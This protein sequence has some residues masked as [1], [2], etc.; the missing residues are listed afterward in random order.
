MN[1]KSGKYTNF[2]SFGELE[3]DFSDQGLT[4]ISGA[5]G[6]GKSTLMDAAAWCL[7][8]E[9][10][11]GGAVD[12]IRTW[13]ESDVTAGS[14]RVT[15]LAGDITVTRIR[16]GGTKNDLFWT[17]AAGQ[18]K[19]G[20][21]IKETQ[22][23]LNS[24]LGISSEL[25]FMAAYFHQFSKADSFFVA[26][27]KERREVLEKIADLS[28]ADKIA[29]KTSA[30][31]KADRAEMEKLRQERTLVFGRQSA[32]KEVEKTTKVNLDNWAGTNERR[33]REISGRM[34]NFEFDKQAA[35]QK[36]EKDL[37]T[38]LIHAQTLEEDFDT[39]LKEAKEEECQFLLEI[40]I[41][42]RAILALTAHPKKCPTCGQADNAAE[43]DEVRRVLDDLQEGLRALKEEMG[44]ILA[45]K[46]VYEK[47]LMECEKGKTVLENLKNT[48]NKYEEELRALDTVNPYGKQLKETQEHLANAG[49]KLQTLEA[50]IGSLEHQITSITQI[51]D[52]S[53]K[54]RG[55]LLNETV[56]SIEISTNQILERYFDGD[57]QVTF[58]L[59]GDKVN[60][61]I[62][63]D[64]FEASFSR[65]S[66]GQRCQL[67]LAFGIS[68]MQAAENRAGVHFEEI[69]LDES[70]NGLDDTL[71]IK[72]FGLFQELATK[73]SSVFV[74]DHAPAFQNLF[75]NKYLVTLAGNRSVIEKS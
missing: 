71:K 50:N 3:F 64:G 1:L 10:S 52:L 9:T 2:S 5:T 28:L 45:D 21:D 8:G 23:L 13:G 16:G 4:L 49:S 34:A 20:K 41:R 59:D 22:Q 6:A 31:R 25:Y 57:I 26:P 14:Q 32:L 24:R 51:F 69:F 74:I 29:E 17:E 18:S 12:E 35:I 37:R 15:T 27:A 63:K 53:A 33:I 65:L 60:A 38:L 30:R 67:K 58:E 68:L 56:K 44:R 75:D 39:L 43:I 72:A 36:A 19:R 66:G 46:H 11:K 73:H 70:L 48:Q 42:K 62:G 47:A 7:F 55:E 40:N 54:L 61:Q